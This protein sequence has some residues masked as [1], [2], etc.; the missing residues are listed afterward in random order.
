ML[1]FISYLLLLFI[2]I[3]IPL[4]FLK[5]DILLVLANEFLLLELEVSVNLLDLSHK[6]LLESCTLL[7]DLFFSLSSDQRIIRTRS[8]RLGHE[9]CAS[10]E[11]VLLGNAHAVRHLI[12]R[13]LLH[14]F[15]T[16]AIPLIRRLILFPLFISLSFEEHLFEVAVQWMIISSI[17]ILSVDEVNLTFFILVCLPRLR[18]R[19]IETLLGDV[20][21]F[22]IFL[23]I[24]TKECSIL[25]NI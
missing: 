1:D 17:I 16:V 2:L 3:F 11:L 7:T 6:V 21:K 24:H 9:V 18:D 5:L 25:F 8:H 22:F 12:S 14:L 13:I 19:C 20:E 23:K 15:T 10:K 4:L